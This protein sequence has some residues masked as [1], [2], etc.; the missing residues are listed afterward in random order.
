MR[1]LLCR[2]A[3]CRPAGSSDRNLLREGVVAG[4]A[5]LEAH[6]PAQEPLLGAPEQLHV[7]AALAA[8]QGRQQ[9]V[10]SISCRS[11]PGFS[12]PRGCCAGDPYPLETKAKRPTPALHPWKP[13]GGLWRTPRQT[14]ASNFKRDCC[15]AARSIGQHLSR[16]AMFLSGEHREGKMEESTHL[17]RVLWGPTVLL[18]LARAVVASCIWIIVLFLFD[19]FSTRSAFTIFTVLVLAPFYYYLLRAATRVL[20]PFL[21]D[22]KYVYSAIPTVFSVAICVGDPVIY[23]VNVANPSIFKVDPSDLKIVNLS[24]FILIRDPVET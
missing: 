1:G 4:N 12:R 20:M 10:V 2:Y 9:R 5:V 3:S 22:M 14:Q 15:P 8:A 23:F 16:C 21:P 6:E 18:A 17:G 13:D 24:L 19:G 7:H 11:W